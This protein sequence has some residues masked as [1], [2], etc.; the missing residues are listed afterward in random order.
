VGVWFRDLRLLPGERLVWQLACNWQQGGIARGGRLGLTSQA[1][2]FEPNRLDRLMGGKSR[3]V[4]LAEIASVGVE[5]GGVKS[6]LSGGMRRRMPLDL[7]NGQRE[8]LLVNDLET[9][10][11]DVEAAVARAR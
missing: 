11:R 6:P 8:L 7:A 5:S 10:I 4:P 2:I 3:R 1:L 9:R